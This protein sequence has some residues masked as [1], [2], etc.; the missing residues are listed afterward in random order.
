MNLRGVGTLLGL[1]KVGLGV[2]NTVGFGVINTVGF[3]VTCLVGKG[4]L[5]GEGVTS[6]VGLEVTFFVGYIYMHYLC[7]SDEGKPLCS[8]L[9][10][11][12]ISSPIILPWSLD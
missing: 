2:R 12:C 7:V 5:V 3:G 8:A 6:F 4:V 10:L 11:L 9:A 1:P